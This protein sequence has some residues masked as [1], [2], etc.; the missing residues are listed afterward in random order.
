MKNSGKYSKMK[1]HNFLFRKVNP[2]LLTVVFIFGTFLVD[3]GL[4]MEELFS[5][6]GIYVFPTPNC[7]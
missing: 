7:R 3:L 2:T 1:F 5:L 4:V 6:A